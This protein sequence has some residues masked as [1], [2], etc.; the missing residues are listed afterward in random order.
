MNTDLEKI[1]SALKKTEELEETVNTNSDDFVELIGLNFSKEGNF[2]NQS[3]FGGLV[4]TFLVFTKLPKH[5]EFRIKEIPLLS[6]GTVLEMDIALKNPRNPSKTR[7]LQGP[8]RIVKRKLV[9]STARPEVMGLSQYLEM[10]PF[11]DV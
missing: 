9:Y 11:Q 10:V 4:R 6:E 1:G 8:Y 7:R 5:I 2:S 3:D